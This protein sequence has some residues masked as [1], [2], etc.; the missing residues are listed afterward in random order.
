MQKPE[1]QNQIHKHRKH[2]D[3]SLT[4]ERAK[5]NESISKTRDISEKKIDSDIQTERSESDRKSSASRKASDSAEV[6]NER[7]S[8]DRKIEIER[9]QSDAATAKEREN[10]K[11]STIEF[12]KQERGET[13]KNLKTERTQ[14][15]LHSKSLS[16]ERKAHL[17]TKVSVTSRDELIAILSHDL[18]NP[19]GAI[20][21]ATDL[22]LG[23]SSEAE[24]VHCI[25]IIKRNTGTAL[26]LIEDIF[27]MESIAAGKFDLHLKKQDL[28]R[29]LGEAVENFASAAAKKETSLKF[30]GA[31]VPVELYFDS[32]RILQVLANLI[33]NALKFIP[34]K[35]AVTV[36]LKLTDDEAVISIRDNGPGISPDK[37]E[38]IKRP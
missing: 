29:L 28:N 9:A 7:N 21:T 20:Y 1:P 34:D 27:E 5:T 17:R 14:S 18:R 35:G 33:G 23:E 25:D 8:S 32:G 4:V 19:L 30:E 10:I 12:L 37:Q 15:D 6:Q 22:M 31:E 3:E 2:T 13:D 38:F 24:L 36:S 16:D 11:E 26:R